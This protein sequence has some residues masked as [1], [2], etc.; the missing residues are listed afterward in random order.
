MFSSP[1]ID[2][3]TTALCALLFVTANAPF[4]YA[5][6]F[7][8][9]ILASEDITL[10]EDG[11]WCWFQDDRAILRGDKVLFS[12]VTSTG[13]NTVT[14][15]NLKTN[16]THSFNL[17]QGTLPPDDHNVSALMVRPDGRYLA[18]YAGHSIDSLVRFRLSDQPG[19][20]RSWGP[21]ET[22][23]TNGRVCYSNVY[24]LSETEETFNFY[25]GNQNNP[26]FL[27]SNDDGSH[28]EF[29]GRLF[30]DFG[31]AYLRY[32]SDG[33]RRIHF[34]TTE[35]HPRHYNNSIYHGY[36]E[37]GNLYRSDGTLVGPISRTA[38][39]PY[40]PTDFT[41]VYDG[42]RSTRAD[43]AWTS[44]IRL[45]E[46]GRPYVVFSVTKD[47]ITRGET[48]N[49]A[50]GGFDHR[51]HFA[52][53]DGE[54]WQERE[55]AYAGSRLYPG[56][57]EYTG[58]I[59]LHPL[60]S[61][62]VYISTDVDPKNGKPLLV[63]GERRYEIFRGIRTTETQWE[64]TPVTYQ[65]KENN[66]RPI[67][68][69]DEEKEIVLWLSG[70][71]ST[72]KDY[73]LAVKGKVRINP[74]R[75]SEAKK[76]KNG[77][78]L[79]TFLISEDPNNY[80]A[81]W[82]I[83][84]FAKALQDD[85]G[86]RTQVLIGSGPREG[87]TLPAIETIPESDLLVVFIRRVGLPKDQL[88]LIKNHLAQGKP[89]LGIRTANH[90]FS[91]PPESLQ[92]GHEAWW[93][94]VPAILGHENRG[95]GSAEQPT[96]VSLQ[97]KHSILKNFPV[98]DWTSQGN[99]YLISPLLHSNTQ[100]LLTGKSAGHQEPIAILRRAGKSKVFYTS[101]GFPTDFSTTPFIQ[102]LYQSIDWT[103]K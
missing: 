99:I 13:D 17:T 91:I 70:R 62:V 29:G 55:I 46:F 24:R 43:V 16:Q 15:W 21:E 32:A 22:F 64:W 10:H 42:D 41:L 97:R 79:V 102:L 59:S 71:Y 36:Y 75:L 28:W 25:R 9:A 73:K 1:P 23:K 94:F 74:S 20:I 89:L 72:Y 81:T 54:R 82:T 98:S 103:L 63:D 58:L 5:F 69:A 39:S 50:L 34:I 68:L 48:R 52:S 35:E 65:S 37:K 93:D 12:G 61:D 4:T 30:E 7:H 18:V 100:T 11:S 44:D 67:V 8:Q 60:R 51:Y 40:K 87:Y 27:L 80:E 3:R 19:D 92:E 14:E 45:D 57:N 38:S 66:I 56:E 96:Q 83:P 86:Y 88:A 78:K 2:L 31:R 53:W 6:Q 90:A 76:A 33:K 101:L 84:A 85:R 77:E 47:P 49:T 26:H 95:Y